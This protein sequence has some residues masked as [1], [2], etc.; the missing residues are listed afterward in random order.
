MNEGCTL[1]GGCRLMTSGMRMTLLMLASDIFALVCAIGAAVVVRYLFDGQ[2]HISFYLRCAPVVVFFLAAYAMRGLYP[3]VLVAPHE[4]LKG[5][6]LGTTLIF[7]F[8][9]TTTFFFKASEEFSRLVMLGGWLGSVILVPFCRIAVRRRFSRRPW[10]GIPAVIWGAGADADTLAGRFSKDRRQGISVLGTVQPD[11]AGDD[12]LQPLREYAAMRPQPML[13]CTPESRD[14]FFSDEVLRIEE[15]F[16]RTL[17]MPPK[18][19]D[20]LNVQ[21]RDVGG[22]LFFQMQTKLLDPVRQRL[23]RT[24]DLTVIMLALPVLLPVMA[25]LAAAVRLEGGGPVFYSQPRIGR[26]GRHFRII[27]FRTMVC[28]ADRVLQQ[29]LAQHPE[30]AEEW[31]E[32]QK[33]RCDPRITAIGGFLRRTSLDE[34]PQLLN[35]LRGEMS[36]VGP[37][38]IVDAEVPR[39]GEAFE[40]YKRTLPGISGLWQISGRNDTTY[41]ERVMLDTYY[42]RNWSVWMDLHVLSRTL[43]VVI[44]RS[45]AY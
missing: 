21:V 37:R 28:N 33:L 8:L 44:K 4:E 11:D 31:A 41:E 5:L 10:W 22:V 30:L 40:L 26:W 12:R 39:Y 35:V 16:E 14:L 42:S 19:F 1:Q 29:H 43:W 20:A 7:F 34:L 27:K 18:A 32:N 2:F 45:G 38:P 24:L 9:I 6:T 15:L 36:L 25:V 3:G 23:K 13:V 17:V